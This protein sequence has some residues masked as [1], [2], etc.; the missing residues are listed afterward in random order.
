M[1]TITKAEKSYFR[2]AKAVSELS[3]HPVRMGCVVV[4]GHRIIGSG[5][6]SKTK[7]SST[8]AKLDRKRYGVYTP[9]HVHCEIAALDY[10]F[11]NNINL[12]RAEIYVYRQYK[13]GNTAMARP[14]CS[15]ME[16]IKRCGIRKIHYTT[17][18]GVVTE[19]VFY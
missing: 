12:R 11:K 9:G 17:S 4:L 15:C 2:A 14:C 16:F 10:L 18:E 7:C 6:N 13:N 1:F 8:Q 3:D 5:C 19:E